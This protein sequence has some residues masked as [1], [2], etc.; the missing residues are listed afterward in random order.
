MVA[1]AHHRLDGQLRILGKQGPQPAHV[2]GV[3][4]GPP[5]DCAGEQVPGGEAVVP[6]HRLPSGVEVEPAW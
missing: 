2:A 3:E 5:V 4:H 6:G 1:P